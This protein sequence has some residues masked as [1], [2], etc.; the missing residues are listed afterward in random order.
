MQDILNSLLTYGYV[1]LFIYSLGGGMVALIAAGVLSYSGQMDL[2]LSILVAFIANAV[3]DSALFYISRYNKSQMIPYLKKHRRKLAL[4]HILMKKYGDK[5][6]FLQK[7]V[8]GIKTLIPIT[9]GFTKYSAFKFNVLNVI[10]AAIWSLIV[11]FASYK[12]G[13]TLV[14]VSKYVSTNPWLAP[15]I[16]T[17]LFGAL[18]LYMQIA[19]K[20]KKIVP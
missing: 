1:I 9:I 14:K 11:A 18:W 20:K 12:A 5:I 3:G 2:S 16:L 7:F 15:L 6:I 17:A 4:S 10:S 8:Y 19:T 13:E